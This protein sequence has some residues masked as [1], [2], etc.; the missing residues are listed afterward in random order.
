M[1][2]RIAAEDPYFQAVRVN[3]FNKLHIMSS[4]ST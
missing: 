4:G 2:D 3:N 1:S